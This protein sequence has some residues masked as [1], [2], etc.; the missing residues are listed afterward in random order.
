LSGSNFASNVVGMKIPS[1]K[2]CKFFDNKCW[3]ET[4]IT[5]G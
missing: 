4:W 2:F 5:W 1:S 3:N